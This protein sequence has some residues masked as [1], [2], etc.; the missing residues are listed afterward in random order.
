MAWEAIEHAVLAPDHHGK[1]YTF[2]GGFLAGLAERDRAKAN[3]LLDATTLNRHWHPFLP[4]M[5]LC[6]GVDRA[7][8]KRLVETMLSQSLPAWTLHILASGRSTDDLTGSDFKELLSVM[9]QKEGGLDAA[10]E[11]LTMRLFSLRSEKKQITRVE[12]EVAKALLEQVTFDENKNREP[13]KLAEIVRHCLAHPADDLLAKRLCQ[14]LLVGIN[15]YKVSPYDYAELVAEIAGVFPR[16]V[17]GEAL[18]PARADS[19]SGRG[20]LSSFR[21]DGQ[22]ALRKIDD[23]VLLQWAHEKPGTRFTALASELIG[24]RSPNAEQ[25]SEVSPEA[26]DI[27]GIKWTP[28]ALRLIHEAPDPIPVLEA[29]AKHLSPMG[30]SGSLADILAGRQP[31][32]DEL[33]R[34][35]DARIA[36]W[37]KAAIPKLAKAADRERQREATEYREQDERFD[38]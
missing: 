12:R 33:S 14:R 32:L 9:A 30:W 20:L 18:E 31:L 24:W 26:D 16:I 23:E 11:I 10:T 35:P 29:F 15:E 38:W 25:A 5:Q 4:H 8:C 34:D 21:E 19:Q 36:K 28:V 17:L 37:A 3:Q 22:C 6:V 7:G 13:H 1:V 27:V 2:P